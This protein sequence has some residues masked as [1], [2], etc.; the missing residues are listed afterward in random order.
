MK[1]CIPFMLRQKS[2]A[3]P[4]DARKVHRLQQKHAG[5]IHGETCVEKYQTKIQK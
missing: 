3:R 2:K 1:A 5:T 4:S